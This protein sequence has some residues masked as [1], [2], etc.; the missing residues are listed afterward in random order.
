MTVKRVL[1]VLIVLSL[2]PIL[3]CAEIAELT[4]TSSTA[5]PELVRQ[6][7][8]GAEWQMNQMKMDVNAGDEL[9]RLL[10]LAD[11]D[12]V[13]GYFYL[14]KGDNIGFEII[15]N[16]SIYKSEGQGTTGSAKID[17]DRFSFVAN[18]AQGTTYTLAFANTNG[19][20]QAK[21][22]IFLEIIYPATG[23]MF[24]PVKTD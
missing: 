3:G 9:L 17:S 5:S 15:G 19:E 8:L 12:S 23:S 20:P 14:E 2:V 18:Q 22:T 1:A 24:I 13:D 4:K 16:S 11:G 21:V 7:E 10:K 6:A